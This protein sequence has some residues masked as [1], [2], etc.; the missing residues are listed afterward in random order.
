MEIFIAIL[1]ILG[2]VIVLVLISIAAALA[3]LKAQESMEEKHKTELSLNL[4]IPI[5]EL[6]SELYS[7]NIIK[8]TAEKFS[9][10][11]FANR[12]SDL[13]GVLVTCWGWVN[14][15]IQ[16]GILGSVIWYTIKDGT[17]NAVYSW[18]LV[19]LALILGIIQSLFSYLCKLVTGRLPGQAKRSRKFIAEWVRNNPEFESGKNA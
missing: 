16:I 14:S 15:I 10:E 3:G 4:G 1:H 17:E 18:L 7:S 13:C 9:D 8:Y 5:D 19:L 2:S 6:E 11:R 12:L